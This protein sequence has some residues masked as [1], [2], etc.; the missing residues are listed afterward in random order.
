[1]NKLS[2]MAAASLARQSDAPALE[3][4]GHWYTWNEV[5]ALADKLTTL[6]DATGA[7]PRGPVVFIARS[8][9]AAIAAFLSLIRTGRTI[10]MVYP[11]Q[12]PA[13]IARDIA[14]LQPSI[15]VSA[16]R[17]LNDEVLTGIRAQGAAA[18]IIS[19]MDAVAVP[20]L[21]R[22]TA[23]IPDDLPAEPQIEIL[24]SGTTGKPKPFAV[25]HDML[26]T[27]FT[28]ATTAGVFG[29]DDKPA[30]PLPALLYYPLGN[31]SGLFSI[32][33]A[34][35]NGWKLIVQDRFTVKGWRDYIVRY[36]PPASGT[37]AAA[38]QMILDADVP[39]EDLASL[40]FFSTGAAPL[41]PRV[42][43]AFEDRYGIPVLLSYGAT[44]FGGPVCA[45]TPDLYTD[46]G[47][48]KF[49]SVGKPFGGAQIRVVDPETRAV[50]AAGQEGLLQVISP[51]MG[52]EWIHTSDLGV[53][54]EDGFLFL[55]GRSDGA[56][57]RGGFKILPETI[58]EALLG[59]PAVSAAS[60][61]GVPDRRLGQVPGAAI[62]IK[63]GAQAPD[64]AE[65]E[66]F[67]RQHV[68][69]TY[70]PVYWMVVD[71]LPK[72]VSLKV[73]RPAVIKLFTD[74]IAANQATTA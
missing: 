12:S 58:Q 6:V 65:L 18:L 40:Q 47:K 7:D 60:V 15:V 64:F 46:F 19:E 8:Q 29:K 52:P 33:P 50:L 51:K 4:E 26:G 9:A 72:T 71:D 2:Q 41:D 27:F 69:A 48:A 56:I 21:E 73:D 63:P 53:L 37:P 74:T 13:G 3:F 45:M 49:G 14:N 38:V 32:L 30:E 16:A 36:Q 39:K 66:A 43:H 28:G 20:G 35:L 68:L 62:Q 67:L 34:L 24:T 44:E 54:D 11:F 25:K 31:I 1:M 17:D 42:Q 23:S 61:V 59:H 57:M 5:V 70:I 55:R 22:S 10:R